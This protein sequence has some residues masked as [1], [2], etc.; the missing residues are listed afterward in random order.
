MQEDPPEGLEFK[1]AM[2]DDSMDKRIR[3]GAMV[4]FRAGETPR[5]GDGVLIRDALDKLHVRYYRPGR[6][7]IWEAHAENKE[8]LPLESERDGL[9]VL[10][11]LTAV[12]GRWG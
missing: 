5:A 7:G 3:K 8:Y 4:Y 9:R 2:P 12:G 1:V 10:A 6:P 11:V